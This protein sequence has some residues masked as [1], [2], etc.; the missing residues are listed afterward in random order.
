VATQHGSG[1]GIAVVAFGR[2]RELDT[3][4][5][6]IILIGPMGAGKTTI[7]RN[8]AKQL[9]K[10]FFD[11]DQEIEKQTGAAINLI[12][13]IEGEEGFRDRESR[14]I[15]TLTQ[16][17]NIVLATGG[18]VILREKNRRALRRS[19][20]VIYLHTPIE[21]QL[22]R[23]TSSKHRPLLLTDDPVERLSSLMSIREPW[24]RQ[25]ADIIVRSNDRSPHSVVRE[26]MRELGA[27]Q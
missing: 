24:Y 8:L 13:E 18:G 12:F 4:A 11:S 22:K 10:K 15:E 23:T 3:P 26:L 1:P 20:T 21:T 14:I 6:N 9:H 2:N 7:G 5:D 17:R 16:R 19:G 25:E 27:S